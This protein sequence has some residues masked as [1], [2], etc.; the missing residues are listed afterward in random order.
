MQVEVPRVRGLGMRQQTATRIIF[1]GP[2]DRMLEKR[3]AEAA[4]LMCDMNPQGG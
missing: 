2:R 1:V 4:A 3:G